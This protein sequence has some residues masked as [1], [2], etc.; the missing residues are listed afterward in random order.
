MT[1]A[2]IRDANGKGGDAGRPD[3]RVLMSRRSTQRMAL[4][5]EQ[6]RPAPAF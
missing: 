4:K 2:A 3:P 5:H 1:A 6:V